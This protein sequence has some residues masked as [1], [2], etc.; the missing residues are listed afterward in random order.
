M[1]NIWLYD[2]WPSIV[3]LNIIWHMCNMSSAHLRVEESIL[4]EFKEN[5]SIGIRFIE[6]TR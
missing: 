3:T 6:R 2:I 1:S 4:A 5:P